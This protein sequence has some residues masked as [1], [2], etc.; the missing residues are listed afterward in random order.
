LITLAGVKPGLTIEAQIVVLI[1]VG[2]GLVLAF[3]VLIIQSQKPTREP[4]RKK[5]RRRSMWHIVSRYMRLFSGS[6]S[7]LGSTRPKGQ[8]IDP[9]AGKITIAEYASQWQSAAASPRLHCRHRRTGVSTA[10]LADAWTVTDGRRTFESHSCVGQG[11]SR[12]L[13]LVLRSSR[14]QLYQVD[15]HCCYH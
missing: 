4:S 1:G 11:D 5:S 3:L 7:P 9:Q 12:Q 15:V 13:L 8:Y 6:S 2:S 14:L 10:H